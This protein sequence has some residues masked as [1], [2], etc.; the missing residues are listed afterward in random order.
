MTAGGA[1]Y[2]HQQTHTH[3]HAMWGDSWNQTAKCQE[4]FTTSVDD[5]QAFQTTKKITKYMK[6]INT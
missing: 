6:L 2:E 4:A 5:N 1:T 3:T